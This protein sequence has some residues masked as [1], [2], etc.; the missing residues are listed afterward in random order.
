VQQKVAV[1]LRK[2][3]EDVWL[4]LL[5][6]KIIND[7]SPDMNVVLTD[8]RYPNEYA[9]FKRLGF[10]ILKIN[11]AKEVRIGRMIAAGDNFKEDDLEFET[12]SFIDGIPF[13][14]EILNESSLEV[15]EDKIAR[16]MPIISSFKN[17]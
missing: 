5:I 17:N 1:D 10:F 11:A 15:L 2:H 8:L 13:D 9:E 4:K 14:Y 6:R 12:E 7:V 16:L 3:D